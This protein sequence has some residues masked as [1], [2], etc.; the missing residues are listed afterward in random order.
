[1]KNKC[2]TIYTYA[3]V[4]VSVASLV[5]SGCNIS[6]SSS[7]S[8]ISN[9]ETKITDSYT[10]NTSDEGDELAK[11]RKW[12]DYFSEDVLEEIH[13]DKIKYTIHADYSTYVLLT[14]HKHQVF[15]T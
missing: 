8:E 15:T 2:K 3:L 10:E 12:I 1:M 6:N 4:F 13:K 11:E 9:S 14:P 7:T 5:L